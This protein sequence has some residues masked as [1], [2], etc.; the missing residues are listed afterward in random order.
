MT[1]PKKPS[2]SE[3]IARRLMDRVANEPYNDDVKL[4]A[5]IAEALDQARREGWEE[6]NYETRKMIL[7]DAYAITFQTMGQYRTQM[8]KNVANLKYPEA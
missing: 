8:A 6:A 4:E 2:E 1:H 7:D 3:K 5:E